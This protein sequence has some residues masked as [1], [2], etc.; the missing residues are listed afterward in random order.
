MNFKSQLGDVSL[1]HPYLDWPDPSH[2]HRN[3]SSDDTTSSAWQ[4]GAWQNNFST[5]NFQD[6]LN[7][8][9]GKPGQTLLG[10]RRRTPNED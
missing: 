10:Q 7:S 1:K 6:K 4:P 8:I 3:D 9:T 2:H 5:G